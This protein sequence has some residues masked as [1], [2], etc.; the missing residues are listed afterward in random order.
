MLNLILCTTGKNLCP[1]KDAKKLG[2]N[3][4][5]IFKNNAPCSSVYFKYRSEVGA[6]LHVNKGCHEDLMIEI[7]AKLICGV[8]K[9]ILKPVNL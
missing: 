6:W 1:Q 8:R 7:L 9:K 5:Q 4:I 2:S 3:S